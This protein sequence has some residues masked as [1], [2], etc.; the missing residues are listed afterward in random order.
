MDKVR[1]EFAV[2]VDEVD[3]MN[4]DQLKKLVKSFLVN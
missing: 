4:S 2:N 1:K 3:K